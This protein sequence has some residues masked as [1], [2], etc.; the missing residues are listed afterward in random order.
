MAKRFYI[1]RENDFEIGSTITLKG[2]EFNHIVNVLRHKEGDDITLFNG[3]G[4]DAF[5]VIEKIERGFLTLKVNSVAD[6]P[7]DSKINVTVFQALVKGEKLELIVQKATELGITKIVPFSSQFCQIKANTF[8]PDRLKKISLEAVKQCGRSKLPV[9]EN[10]VKFNEVLSMLAGYDRVIFAYENATEKLNMQR[11]KGLSDVA[12]IV[13]SEGGFS[14][15]EAEEL[16]RLR[17]VDMITL[18]KR[19]L[20]AETASIC[21]SALVMFALGEMD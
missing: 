1:E 3:S 20:R 4:K 19:I 2:D 5:S 16:C 10:A 6:C 13:G 18:G 8:R 12:I 15:E 14:K 7:A 9:I 11:L 21:L 17:N